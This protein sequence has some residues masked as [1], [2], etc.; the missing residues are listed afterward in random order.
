[1]RIS[2]LFYCSSS[3]PSLSLPFWGEMGSRKK[4]KLSRSS[5]LYLL[6][7]I[8]C[9]PFSLTGSSFLAISSFLLVFRDFF[10]RNFPLFPKFLKGP[11]LFQNKSSKLGWRVKSEN[12]GAAI[13]FRRLLQFPN[14]WAWEK[15]ARGDREI[16]EMGGGKGGGLRQTI[17]SLPPL[18]RDLLIP[19]SSPSPSFECADFHRRLFSGKVS[20]KEKMFELGHAPASPRS[21][22]YETQFWIEEEEEEERE[23]KRGE[24][25]CKVAQID[26]PYYCFVFP[27]LRLTF[28]CI[29]GKYG[30]VA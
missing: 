24:G 15:E 16:W 30:K 12:W 6:S 1:M 10:L 20:P 5:F 26:L 19:R 18:F 7:Y 8:H 9:L 3:S 14:E 22:V 28:L 13:S 21:N 25:D 17:I 11:Q 4:L 2:P 23:G 29:S 27:Q